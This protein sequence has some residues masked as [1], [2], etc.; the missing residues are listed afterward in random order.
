M[1]SNSIF[2]VFVVVWSFCV[3]ELKRVSKELKKILFLAVQFG[4]SAK[5]KVWKK[6]EAFCLE[7]KRQQSNKND[8]SNSLFHM[9]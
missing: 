9:R 7:K 1:Y 6:F 4:L 2:L 5:H 8:Y 3:F